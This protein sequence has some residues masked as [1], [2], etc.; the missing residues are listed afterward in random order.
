MYPRLHKGRR[1]DTCPPG[2]LSEQIKWMLETPLY[3]SPEVGQKQLQDPIVQ[4]DDGILK[5]LRQLRNWIKMRSQTG[6]R[7]AA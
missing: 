3:H 7:R 5:R 4:D 1:T 2:T 6:Q